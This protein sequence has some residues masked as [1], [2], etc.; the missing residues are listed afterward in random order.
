MAWL[1]L[2]I[3]GFALGGMYW[4]SLKALLT[5]PVTAIQAALPAPE[6]PTLTVNIAFTEYSNLLAQRESAQ[7][8]GAFIANEADFQQATIEVVDENGRSQEIP[9]RLRLRQGTAESLGEHDKWPFDVRTRSDTTLWGMS[10]FTL[11]DPASNNWLAQWAF[12]QAAAREGLLVT[13][14]QFV[15][16]TIN[17][18]SKGIYALQ[19]GFSQELLTEQAHIPGVIIEFNGDRL[20]QTI[21]AQDGDEQ[22]ILADPFTHLRPADWHLLTIDAVQD[23]TIENDAALLAQRE[24]AISRLRGLQTGTETAGAIFD[25]AQYGTLLALADWWDAADALSWVNLRFY[26]NPDTD[27]LEPIV[28]SG[29]PLLVNGRISSAYFYNDSDV[30]QAYLTAV[31]RLTQPDYLDQLQTDLD[32]QLQQ[33]QRALQ[34][35][36]DLTLPWETLR[37]RQTQL[38]QSLAPSQPILAYFDNTHADTLQINLASVYNLPLQLIGFDIGGA[39]FLQANPAW[40]QGD[41]S[42][43]LPGTEGAVILRPPATDTV[44]FVQFQ[45]P[46]LEI[47]R[48]DSELDGLTGIEI[49]I[50]TQIVGLPNVQLT[51]AR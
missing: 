25:T 29:Q 5:S 50:A 30:Q 35:E 34:A 11:Q 40:I 24:T 39:T 51:P 36:T 43:L 8:T 7:T 42:A 49:N 32:P 15:N 23:N 6:L 10:R 12:I 4:Q 47:Q 17:G 13:R 48:L 27:L 46:I 18:D 31:Q 16:L 26:Y 28:A 2:F 45:I 20:W 37:Q 3:A 21:Q 41:T 1:I 14:Y 9:V 38:Q 33:L 22:A 19:E 44:Y